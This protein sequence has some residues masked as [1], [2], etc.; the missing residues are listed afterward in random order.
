MKFNQEKTELF[1]QITY[2]LFVISFVFYLI[3][4]WVDRA[5]SAYISLYFNLNIILVVVFISGFLTVLR[6]A[7]SEVSPKN[8]FRIFGE[9]H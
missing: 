5:Y 4:S 3:F 8:S 9:P 6:R 7:R 1:Y 2:D